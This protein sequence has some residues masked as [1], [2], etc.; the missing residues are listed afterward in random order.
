MK[1]GFTCGSFD[2]LHA[3]HILMLKEAREQCDLLIVGLQTDPSID[4]PDKNEPVQDMPE[5]LCQLQAVRY[6][7]QVIIYSTEV[8]LLLTLDQVKPDV[9]I[10]GADWEGK[11]F[12]GHDLP[13]PVYFNTRNHSMSTSG[14]RERIWLAENKPRSIGGCPYGCNKAN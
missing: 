6:V 13:I 14:L 1:I 11:K 4:R 3:G 9:R 5:R 8:E 12:T 2:L 7:D 10:V